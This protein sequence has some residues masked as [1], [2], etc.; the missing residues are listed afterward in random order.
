M[1]GR[2]WPSNRRLARRVCSAVG[3]ALLAIAATEAA[4]AELKPTPPLPGGSFYNSRPFRDHDN[5]LVVVR[6]RRE[7]ARGTITHISGHVLDT[8]GRPLANVRVEI[9]QTDAFGYYPSTHDLGGDSNFQGYGATE[10]DSDGRY[11]FRTVRPG[12]VPGRPPVI[13]FAVSGAGI[14]PLISQMFIDDD[15]GV[16][17][18]FILNRISDPEQRASLMVP[19]LPA[20]YLEPGALS[21]HFDIVVERR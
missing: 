5:D 8:S 4:T 6:W 21:G 16:A 7:P 13:H 20:P 3:G 18:D 17:D 9:W 19:L 1:Q 10:T 14:K 15:P 2:L 12:A 11:Q